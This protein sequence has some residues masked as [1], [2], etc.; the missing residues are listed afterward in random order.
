[1]VSVKM[2]VKAESCTTTPRSVFCFQH[3]LTKLRH[4]SAGIVF[5]A[6]WCA[7]NKTQQ[8]RQHAV[9]TMYF[10]CTFFISDVHSHPINYFMNFK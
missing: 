5:S 4:R 3:K 1:M 10:C 6:C 8:E 9:F 2:R 7:F